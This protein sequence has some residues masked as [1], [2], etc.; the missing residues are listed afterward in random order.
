MRSN[1]GIGERVWRIAGSNKGLPTRSYEVV[2]K[3]KIDVYLEAVDG[4]LVWTSEA[5]DK[6][7]IDGDRCVQSEKCP[8]V[9][10]RHLTRV[11]H[12]GLREVVMAVEGRA[13][14]IRCLDAQ[15][16]Q[17]THH[18]VTNRCNILVLA[19]RRDV[20][21]KV[22]VVLEKERRRKKERGKRKIISG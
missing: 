15:V 11:G 9:A 16:I 8:L 19:V 1:P 18:Y 3:S 14:W 2:E 5:L 22:Q 6:L 7:E 13:C 12:E 4:E 21:H 17:H 10:C 20:I